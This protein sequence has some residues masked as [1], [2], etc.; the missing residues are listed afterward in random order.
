MREPGTPLHILVLTDRDWTHPQ[1]GGTGTNL[2]GYLDHWL[3]WGH[4][5]TVVASSYPGAAAT[6]QH[7]KLT[8]QRAG[9]LQTAIPHA[10]RRV[11]RGLVP[12]A[13]VVLE[14]VNGVMFFTPL[15]LRTPCV[16]LVHHPS[17]PAQYELEFGRKG[18]IAAALLERLPLR[19]LYGSSRFLTLSEAGADE[20]AT[21]GVP[22]EHTDVVHVGV[23]A[24]AYRPGQR[25]PE[26]T[27]LYL[28]R[29]KRYKRIELLF[30]VL[31]RVPGTRLEL[32][33]EGDHREGLEREIARRGLQQ[34]VRMHGFVDEQTKLELLQR[35]WVNVTASSAEGWGL[36]VME[37]GCCETPSA[38]LAV[39]GLVESIEHEHSGLLAADVDGLATA[40]GRL[41]EDEPLRE[42]MGHAALERARGFTW[43]RSAGRALEA[44]ERARAA[45]PQPG[46]LRSLARSDSG[47]AAGLAAAAMGTNVIALLFTIVF[48]RVLG[49]N[50][51]GALI[52][53]LAAF[54]VIAIP[55]QALQ[56]TVAREVSREVAGHDPSLSGNVR[57]WARTLLALALVSAPICA[58]LREQLAGL[59]GVD[60]EWAAAAI[61]PM[62][63]LW[64]LLSIQRGVLQGIGSY[65]LVAASLLGEAAG[66]L[67][68]A[69]VFVGAGLGA[70][71]AF[72]GLSASIATMAALLTVPLHRRL[73]ALGAGG[74]EPTRRLSELV[75]GAGV[76]LLALALVAL[77]QNV[78][79]IVVN[80]V[81]S[82]TQASAYAAVS[83]AAKAVVW[84]AIGLGL[85]VLP[86]AA[87]RAVMGLDGRPI[88]LRALGLVAAVGLPVT[89]VYAVAGHTVLTV[90]FGEDLASAS[91]ALPWLSLAMTLLAAVYISVQ[92]MLALDRRAFLVLLVAAALVEPVALALIGPHFTAVALAVLAIELALA[93]GMIGL[94]LRSS[95]RVAA[96]GAVARRA[97]EEVA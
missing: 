25:A 4:R 24:D 97:R 47:R 37:A 16:T 12:D 15:W 79:V 34:R 42:R 21:L 20:L 89:L 32:A 84:V 61:V 23:D 49:E 22:R 82:D 13:D 55:G 2:T 8:I 64:L 41:V 5:V 91:A 26:P 67:T 81:A 87:R 70:S 62:G 90:A 9:R 57:S 52:A 53:L 51:Y 72:V 83:V 7:G 69:L 45:G 59:I 28:G 19:L 86:E 17:S 60:L 44:L 30:D 11:S 76:P 88:L 50:D 40:V 39:G 56:V 80:N 68:Y 46:F 74:L 85:F 66:R 6:E 94:A 65:R 96:V 48:A 29:L 31:E 78:D 71:G 14:V 63:L 75:R 77:L 43:E 18:R 38:A 36:T 27:L 95:G 10:V 33:G 92:F 54:L 1:G 58:L 35:A 3:A 93:A 73:T